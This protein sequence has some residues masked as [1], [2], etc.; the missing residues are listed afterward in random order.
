VRCWVVV[1]VSSVS[2]SRESYYLAG[3][4]LI[5]VDIYSSEGVPVV[6]HGKTLTSSVPLSSVCEAIMKYAFVASP[7]PVIISAEVC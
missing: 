5:A 6:T 3:D 7:Y 4:C 2:S 1:E